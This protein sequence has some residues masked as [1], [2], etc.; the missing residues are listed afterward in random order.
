[1]V[2]R[3]R[4]ARLVEAAHCRLQQDV[5]VGQYSGAANQIAGVAGVM[6]MW[7][8]GLVLRSWFLF[9]AV[10]LGF[11]S[12]SAR[13]LV[14]WEGRPPHADSFWR[15]TGVA[16]GTTYSIQYRAGWEWMPQRVAD[17]LF[18]VID[19]SLSI[20]DSNSLISRF[21][22]NPAGMEGDVHLLRMLQMAREYTTISDGAFDITL[23][24]L[25]ALWGF[26]PGAARRHPTEKEIQ[27]ALRHTGIDHIRITGTYIRKKD[28]L[29]Q[30]DCNGIAQ[31]Y[32]VD[33]LADYLRQ[34]GVKDYLVELGGEIRLSGLNPSG[35]PWTIGI[36]S[37]A[38]LLN[39]SEPMKVIRPGFGAITSSGIYRNQRTLD[40]KKINHIINPETGYPI[41]NGMISVTVWTRDATLS[42]ALDNILMVLGPAEILPFLNAHPLAEAYWVFKTPDGRLMEGATRGFDEIMR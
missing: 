39:P 20:Y 12:F 38:H 37:A 5:P 36:E 28:P 27:E 16:Q 40:G 7:I 32:T 1:M 35:E 10:G 29:L 25:S 9:L 18:R 11:G 3:T 6:K 17:S 31:G 19:Q 42:D 21:N 24:S 34:R 2:E 30:I 15:I 4:G 26:G 14:E 33:L 13:P 8:G 41:S 23:K 22:R